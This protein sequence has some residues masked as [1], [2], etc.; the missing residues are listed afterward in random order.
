MT[1]SIIAIAM[2]IGTMAGS[3][4]SADTQTYSGTVPIA[5]LDLSNPA[6]QAI[7]Q[8]RIRRMAWNICHPDDQFGLLELELDA[9]RCQRQAIASAQPQV[10]RA[11]T[12]AFAR[13]QG[14]EGIAL[15]SRR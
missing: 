6:D 2:M 5:G 11:V 9:Q 7:V 1:K 14:G 10:D 12:L 15:A 8:K 13:K 4:A 3:P